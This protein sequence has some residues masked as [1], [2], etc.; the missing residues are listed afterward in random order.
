MAQTCLLVQGTSTQ[1]RAG[2]GRGAPGGLQP[3][4]VPQLRKGATAT[5][6]PQTLRA[7]DEDSPAAEVTFSIQPPVNGKV[8][9]RPAPGVEVRR[10]TQAQI[11][12]G[13]VLFVHQ[14]TSRTR[15]PLAP[16]LSPSPVAPRS[17]SCQVRGLPRAPAPHFLQGPWME[18]S[19]STCGTARTCPLGTS[20]SS[21]R[22]ARSSAWPR[23]RASPSAQVG[24]GQRAGVPAARL[25]W[26]QRGR[27]DVPPGVFS[28]CSATPHEREP[29]GGEQQPR[30]P[31][32]PLLQHRA[33]PAPWPA[34]HRPRGRSQELYPSPGEVSPPP[35]DPPSAP[36]LGGPTPFAG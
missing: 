17:P 22:R 21:G 36:Q 27:V 26:G 25:L 15:R 23:S 20:S 9:L 11:D 30:Q 24:R 31:H 7:E 14:G 8:V 18:A 13:L 5:I 2:D 33:S 32:G 34:A 1:G 12:S 10:F 16:P 28:R 6:G 35:G 29:A 3:L 19:P 4:P